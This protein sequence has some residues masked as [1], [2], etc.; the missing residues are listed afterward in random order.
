LDGIAVCQNIRLKDAHTPILFLTAKNSGQ[1]KV[2][3]LRVGADDYLTKPF[4]LEELL[5]RV[6]VLIRHS[7]RGKVVSPDLEQYS[8]DGNELNFVTY[9][10]VNCHGKTVSLSKKDVM[11]L[12]LLINRKDDVVSRQEILNAVW[13]YEVF[14]STRTIDNFIMTFRKHFERD[15]SDPKHFH[16]VRGIGYKFT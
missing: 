3:G 1:D 16:S 11:L 2:D 12:K 14:P 9:E 10:A 5:L 8:F 15:P 13:G 7:Q 6:K 4:N